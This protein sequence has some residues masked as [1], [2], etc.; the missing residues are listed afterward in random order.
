MKITSLDPIIVTPEVEAAKKVFEALGFENTHA[1]SNTIADKHVTSYRMKHP[2][3]YH[4]DV[5]GTSEAISRDRT[6]IRLNV[7]DFEE[8]YNILLARGYK[9]V[10]GD[11][12][13]GTR[14]ATFATMEAPSGFR[15][16]IVKHI[17]DHE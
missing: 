13:D 12:I 16:S 4:V 5:V 1:P 7:D 9:N 17:K 2:N 10:H 6:L 8:A 3:G 15:I 14:S 11:R